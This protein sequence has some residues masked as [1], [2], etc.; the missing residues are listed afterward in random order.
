L[1]EYLV[2]VGDDFELAREGWE[3][4]LQIIQISG[5]QT[6]HGRSFLDSLRNNF[7]LFGFQNIVEIF[8]IQILSWDQSTD[9][10]VERYRNSID[11]YG[12]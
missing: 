11:G 8:N 2:E 12:K 1:G 4:D 9:I 6:M 10:L 5:N 7:S 3:G